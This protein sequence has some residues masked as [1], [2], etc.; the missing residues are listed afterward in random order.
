MSSQ[1]PPLAATGIKINLL[2]QHIAK[3]SRTQI[4]NISNH[5]VHRK[6]IEISRD[7]SKIIHW[8]R[9]YS[10]S[11]VRAVLDGLR[12]TGLEYTGIFQPWL[13]ELFP[14]GGRLIQLAPQ[15]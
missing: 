11:A 9:N 7:L 14:S 13:S 10:D 4:A 3:P 2:C 8:V 12:K 1:N 5:M 15:S 6:H